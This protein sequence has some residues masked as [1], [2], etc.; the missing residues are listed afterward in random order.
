MNFGRMG[1]F[2]IM[3]NIPLLL[4]EKEKHVTKGNNYGI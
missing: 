2:N 4:L 3:C 1:F